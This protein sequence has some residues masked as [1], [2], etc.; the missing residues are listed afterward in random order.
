MQAHILILHH[1]TL[2]L[3]Q[4]G[5]DVNLLF[6]IDGWRGE[7]CAQVGLGGAVVRDRVEASSR[8]RTRPRKASHSMH[9]L[10]VKS[11]SMS[12]LRQRSTSRAVC[13]GVKPSSTSTLTAEKRLTRSS[14]VI[15]AREREGCS[16]CRVPPR[17]AS[18]P[19]RSPDS[20]PA[21]GARPTTPFR[22]ADGWRWRPDAH[23]PRPR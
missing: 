16:R 20:S 17:R 10:A 3:R 22:S 23:A 7:A 8:G 13:S 15:L 1:D 9:R 12:Q 4:L 14:C 21:R 18:P 19:W 2:G 6:G 5:G 11:V